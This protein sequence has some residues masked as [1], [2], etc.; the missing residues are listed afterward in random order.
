MQIG[1]TGVV[2]RVSLMVDNFF[3]SPPPAS[4]LRRLDTLC[5]SLGGMLRDVVLAVLPY[6]PTGRRPLPADPR[7]PM[8]ALRGE[9]PRMARERR[10]VFRLSREYG[11]AYE[12]NNA[13]ETVAQHAF[14]RDSPDWR[15]IVLDD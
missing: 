13:W 3:V 12:M 6:L 8:R 11:I 7:V 2:S 10:L 1:L 14:K 9:M 5:A 4:T 15:D